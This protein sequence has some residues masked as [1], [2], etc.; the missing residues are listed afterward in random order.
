VHFTLPLV[1]LFEAIP[2]VRGS[3]TTMTGFVTHTG[4]F[5]VWKLVT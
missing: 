3:I 4:C 2:S 1:F 5:L